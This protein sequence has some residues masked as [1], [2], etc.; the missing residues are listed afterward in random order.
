M[1]DE[2]PKAPLAPA[3]PHYQSVNDV[4]QVALNRLREEREQAPKAGSDSEKA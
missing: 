4:V 3:K 2:K 1:A